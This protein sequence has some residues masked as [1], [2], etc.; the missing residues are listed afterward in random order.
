M[1][2]LTRLVRGTVAHAPTIA[3]TQGTVLHVDAQPTSECLRS[4]REGF[5]GDAQ[6][7]SDINHGQWELKRS[8]AGTAL[9]SFSSPEIGLP[10]SR[11][12]MV[13]FA[14][15]K[16]DLGGGARGAFRSPRRRR[17]QRRQRGWAP[18]AEIVGGPSP[19]LR[20]E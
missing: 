6:G 9:M 13:V 17:P 1:L 4:F 20:L 14:E 19:R 2:I 3:P 15:A 8:M 5:F 10:L 16:G 12:S 18:H 11:P 7:F